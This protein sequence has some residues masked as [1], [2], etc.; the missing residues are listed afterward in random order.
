MAATVQGPRRRDAPRSRRVILDAAEALFAQRG[1]DATSMGAIA[2]G[3]GVSSALPAYFFGDKDGLYRAVFERCFDE[4]EERL[5][6]LADEVV[7]VLDE[8]GELRDALNHLIDGYVG[9]LAQ[10]RA[11]VRLIAW[12]ALHGARRLRAAPRH[13]VAVERALR[14]AVIAAGP[15]AALAAGDGTGSAPARTAGAAAAPPTPGHDF[16]QLLIS[17]VALCFFGFEHADTMLSAM[18]IDAADPA[19]VAARKAHVVDVLMRILGA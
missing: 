18:G 6:P 7:A 19:F 4:R 13:S 2:R 3:A 15:A 8:G 12:E 5:A 10:R 9:F 1:Y 17:V 11:F 16:D 14:A